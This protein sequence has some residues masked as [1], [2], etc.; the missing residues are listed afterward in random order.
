[1][2]SRVV[3]TTGGPARDAEV[4][5][6]DAAIQTFA[7]ATTP[8]AGPDAGAPADAAPLDNAGLSTEICAGACTSEAYPCVPLS[9]TEFTCQ[10]QL[11]DWPMP[12][13]VPGAKFA[14]SYDL[15]SK[16][17]V[18]IDL[19]TGLE[20]QRAV[21]DIYP[22][23]TVHY[24]ETGPTASMVHPTDADACR[25]DEALA[26]C[27]ALKLG[28]ETDWRVPTR[29]ELASLL[30]DTRKGLTLDTEVFLGH[31]N[32]FFW[33]ADKGP[34]TT[35]GWALDFENGDA[36]APGPFSLGGF[37]GGR[38]V[39]CVRGHG[40]AK[41]VPATRYRSSGASSDV[42][43]ERTKLS[44]RRSSG[45]AVDWAT[46]KA[47]CDSG[48]VTSQTRLPTRKELLTLVDPLRTNPTLDPNAFYNAPADWFWT[49][50]PVADRAAS[51]HWAVSFE[52]GASSTRPDLQLARARCV[53]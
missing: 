49:S 25:R 30:D 47:A 18:V 3:P 16:P 46:A 28:D 14:P 22:G 27:Y 53:Y 33:I 26:Y 44:W 29:I 17:G 1:M 51:A 15:L 9:G 37:T 36:A 23:C 12:D 48:L 34:S 19:V 10:G 6:G 35:S 7:D 41:G 45:E 21:P 39:R 24:G 43:D 32:G 20:W 52:N 5:A 2:P 8:G 42:Y 11:A 13:S 50:T 38:Y 40:F 31:A 4:S